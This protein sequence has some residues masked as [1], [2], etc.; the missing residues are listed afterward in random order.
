MFCYACS[1]P[2]AYW[3]GMVHGFALLQQTLEV[4]SLGT[5]ELASGLQPIVDAF[6]SQHGMFTGEAPTCIKTPPPLI[7]RGLRHVALYLSPQ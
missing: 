2:I 6:K 5:G 1:V 3:R 4:K 7:C